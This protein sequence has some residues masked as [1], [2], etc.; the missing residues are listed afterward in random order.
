VESL[1]RQS[2]KASGILEELKSQL[3]E[4]FNCAS[5]EEAEKLLAK[6]EKEEETL[7]QK[8]QELIEECEE[9]YDLPE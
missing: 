4:E 6:L 5:L 7:K 9:K 2:A 8:K 3:K 1:K